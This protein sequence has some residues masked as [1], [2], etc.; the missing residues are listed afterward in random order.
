MSGGVG[1]GTTIWEWNGPNAVLVSG[2]SVTRK[3]GATV[4]DVLT[5]G[6][7]ALTI[8]DGK[9]T[10]YTASGRTTNAIA[11]GSAASPAGHS[12]GRQR[13]PDP[14]SLRLT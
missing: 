8:A 4:V 14:G 2:N 3:P 10:G 1:T 11:T 7:L 12:H 6:K 13:A 5:E 9:V